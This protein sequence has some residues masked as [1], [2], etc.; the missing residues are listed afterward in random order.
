M[1]ILQKAKD[2]GP[3]SPVDAYFLCE[4]KGLFSIALLKF[5]PG[6]RENYHNHAFNAWTWFLKG[7]MVEYTYPIGYY[8]YER[9][10]L[11]KVTKKTDMH[12][13]RAFEESWA[14]TLRGPWSRTWK[15]TTPGGIE[16]TLTHG[17]KEV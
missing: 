2:G 4:F 6:S 5:N 17:R 3:D 8:E 13:V 7:S 11:P 15:E 14:F 1:R 16:T 9:S 12:K 10:I